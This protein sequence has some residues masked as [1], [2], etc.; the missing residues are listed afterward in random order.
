MR[1]TWSVLTGTVLGALILIL[2]A[3]AQMSYDEGSSSGMYEGSSLM[4]DP[5]AQTYG[6]M[7]PGGYY[8]EWTNYL[9]QLQREGGYYS[10]TGNYPGSAPVT[11]YYPAGQAPQ[12]QG[13]ASGQAAGMY[14]SPDYYSSSGQQAYQQPQQAYGQQAYSQPVYPQQGYQQ[15]PTQQSYAYQGPPAAGQTGASGQQSATGKSKKRKLTATQRGTAAQTYEQPQQQAYPQ[16]YPQQ[17]YQQQAYQQPG[18]YP[19]AYPQGYQQQPYQQGYQQPQQAYG[20]QAYP[21]QGQQAYG[22]QGYPQQGQQAYGQQ[23]GPEQEDPVLQQARMSAYERAVARQRA[24]ELAAQQQAAI[25]ELQQTRQQ[26]DA[27]Q[28]RLQEQED[29]QRAFQEEYRRKAAQEAYEQLR[30]AQ[31]RYYD[32]VGVSGE[33]GRPDARA[34]SAGPSRGGYAPPSQAPVQA[35]QYG[36]QPAPYQQGYPTPP[37][38]VG[39][40]E[41]P[42]QGGFAS[43]PQAAG[44]VTPLQ[45]QQPQSQGG[46]LWSTLKEIFAPPTTGGPPA[47][48]L[49]EDRNR[50]RD[51]GG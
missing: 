15:P 2:P 37:Q 36:A 6:M 34:A 1:R 49:I 16:T 14:S 13:Q 26:Y 5:T 9:D 19:Q 40:Q 21:Q 43:T 8:P 29:R 10:V 32:L 18:A 33:S 30:A 51:L 7:P 12:M 50:N 22:Q 48:S 46:G 47:R 3:S 45:I 20:Q 27:A 38:S 25:Q 39:M 23:A 11:S 31:Q 41:A 28:A 17:G 24:A 42:Q 44:Q 4:Q 35:Q